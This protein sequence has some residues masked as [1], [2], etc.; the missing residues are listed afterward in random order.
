MAEPEQSA[1]PRPRVARRLTRHPAH[2]ACPPTT[3]LTLQP[4]HG[5]LLPSAS[6][7]RTQARPRLPTTV[8][9][10]PRT[11]PHTSC[12]AL[13]FTSAGLPP[14]AQTQPYHPPTLAADLNQPHTG[15]W[16]CVPTAST[17]L[18]RPWSSGQPIFRPGLHAS[19]S[20]RPS[21]EMP[22]PST[23]WPSSPHPARCRRLSLNG[24]VPVSEPR[25]AS[26]SHGPRHLRPA[27]S[28][29]HADVLGAGR[30]VEEICSSD[31]EHASGHMGSFSPG[32]SALSRRP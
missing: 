23:P 22:C 20:R 18:Q 30:V 2:A 27:L 17:L 10:Q 11:I 6:P 28:P 14:A 21:T 5:H 32:D 1:A 26:T 3:S 31:G 4:P 12:P 7:A 15:A 25:G 13:A 9:L 24:S 8:A 19:P 16:H 29:T